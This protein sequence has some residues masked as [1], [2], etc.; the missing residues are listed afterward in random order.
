[1]SDLLGNEQLY[2]L[3][4]N[5]SERFG[6][7]WDGFQVGLTY[8]N[9]AQRLN[10]GVG[11]F[12]LTEIYDVDLDKVLRERRVGI[13]ALASYPFSK[14]TRL[15]ASALIRHAVDHRLR[16]GVARNADLVSNYLAFVHDN[17]R[18]TEMG[19][20]GGTRLY[21]SAGVTR[22]MSGG[23]GD[24]TSTLVELRKYA[25]PIPNVVFAGRAQTQAS[26]GRDA[27]RNYLGGLSS[28]RGY[29][30]RTLSGLQTI[31]V[32]GEARF[33]VLR[34]LTL[35]VPALWT[36]PTVNGAVFAD[37][38]WTWDP[39]DGDE[40]LWHQLFAHPGSLRLSPGE[41]AG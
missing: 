33:P 5:D 31:L 20:S 1:L 9:R 28:I 4:A 17:S 36:F 6:N 14:F 40:S 19:A 35:A 26:F 29:D 18:W 13:L 39:L 3:L 15:E 32:Q 10:W 2:I 21:A 23:V 24:F 25:M 37:A 11:L 12:R 22:D 27:Q 41:Q 30:R 16:S 7:F 38:A 34:G 8:V